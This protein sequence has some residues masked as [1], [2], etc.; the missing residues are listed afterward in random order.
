MA[1]QL[2]PLQSR[3][4]ITSGSPAGNQHFAGLDGLRGLA[5]TAVYLHHIASPPQVEWNCSPGDLIGRLVQL[6]QGG[7]IGVDL[8]FGLSGFLITGILLKARDAENYF[9]VFYMRRILRIFPLYYLAVALVFLGSTLPWT[10]M[11]KVPWQDQLWFW[12]N[13]SNWPT[14]YKLDLVP[15]LL[16][17]WTLAVEEQ[18]YLVWPLL[19]RTLSMRWL[20]WISAAALPAELAL[21]LLPAMQKIDTAHSNFL[22]R[23]TPTHSEGLFA[24]ALL[25]ILLHRRI[26]QGR[27]LRPLRMATVTLL[28]LT[29]LLVALADLSPVIKQLRFTALAIVFTCVIAIVALECGQGALS[30]ALSAKPLRLLG[31]YSFC[32]YVIHVPLLRLVHEHLFVVPH[33]TRVF[34]LI[35]LAALYLVAVGIAALSWRYLEEPILARKRF[36]PYRFRQV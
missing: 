7:W 11:A 21:R 14:A 34:T 6:M 25:A 16:H 3:K 19:V 28:P 35:Q 2:L 32:I 22:Y 17:F 31:R 18:F 5:V 26:L 30:R 12:V 20:L 27:H 13:L 9:S 36:F 15:A 10:Q 1:T 23:L 24:G 33:L 4:S 29:L 8:F